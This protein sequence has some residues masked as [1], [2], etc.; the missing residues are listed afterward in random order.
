MKVSNRSRADRRAQSLEELRRAQIAADA[1]DYPLRVRIAELQQKVDTMERR[2]R[3][4]EVQRDG[5]RRAAEQLL[6][7]IGDLDAGKVT[8]G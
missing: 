5:Y 1:A 6:A 4:A 7:L 8:G 2:L 3:R